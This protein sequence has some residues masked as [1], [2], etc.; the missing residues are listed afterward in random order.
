MAVFLES[1]DDLEVVVGWLGPQIPLQRLRQDD[2]LGAYGQRDEHQ[3]VSSSKWQ[4][5]SQ[6]PRVLFPSEAASRPV[7]IAQL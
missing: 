3:K 4:P 2:L 7:C 6:L 5:W 1:K